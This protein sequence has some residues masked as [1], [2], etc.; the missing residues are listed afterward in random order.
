[1]HCWHI[2]AAAA[3]S[4]TQ[5]TH[6]A[7]RGALRGGT[8]PTARRPHGNATNISSFSPRRRT[9]QHNRSI[10]NFD[11]FLLAL[12]LDMSDDE[13]VLGVTKE[14]GGVEQERVKRDATQ[15]WVRVSLFSR[16]VVLT[17]RPFAAA[18]WRTT[19]RRVQQHR[20][21]DA[22]DLA[23]RAPALLFSCRCFDAVATSSATTPSRRSPRACWP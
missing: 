15:L 19:R 17:R 7:L 8:R 14:D 20:A 16:F 18:E 3:L 9:R 23:Q 21:A 2:I 5:Q 6:D 10:V 1:M 13:I 22:R 4:S 11:F 12:H